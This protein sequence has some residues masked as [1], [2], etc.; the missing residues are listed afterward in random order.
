MLL[1]WELWISDS[2][3]SC[4]RRWKWFCEMLGGW[5]LLARRLDRGMTMVPHIL[6]RTLGRSLV[7]GASGPAKQVC[8]RIWRG[9]TWK[10]VNQILTDW[11]YWCENLLKILQGFIRWIHIAGISLSSEISLNWAKCIPIEDSYIAFNQSS[12][13][14]ENIKILPWLKH[15]WFTRFQESQI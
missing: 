2:L 3:V 10:N 13:S 4:I 5:S 11:R 14:S 12:N 8:R 15:P 9:K 7:E 1:T 6:R